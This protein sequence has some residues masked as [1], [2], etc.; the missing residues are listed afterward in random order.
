MLAILA[1]WLQDLAYR[2]W[3]GG[4]KT[5]SA[6]GSG[7]A[8]PRAVEPGAGREVARLCVECRT[9]VDEGDHATCGVRSEGR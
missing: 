3:F 8:S 4:P 2:A 5:P 7:S 9:R 1:H 6:P